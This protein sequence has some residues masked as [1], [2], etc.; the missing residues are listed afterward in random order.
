MP[1]SYV[2]EL[3]YD[4]RQMVHSTPRYRGSI[5]CFSSQDD[6]QT[7][8]S[9]IWGGSNKLKYHHTIGSSL[10]H[11]FYMDFNGVDDYN[12]TYVLTGILSWKD[13][14]FDEFHCCVV[15]KTTTYS[16]GSNTNYDLYG[17]YLIIPAA[18]TGSTVVNDADRVL[19]EVPVNEWGVRSGAGYWDADYNQSTK[20][21][22]NITANASGTGKYN[23][24]GTEV[25]FHK[26]VN[27]YIMLGNGQVKLT[28]FDADMLGHNVRLRFDFQT[29]G[30]DHEWKWAG[31]ITM[32]RKRTV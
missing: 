9:K 21:F 18:G 7:D 10:T 23:M 5:T 30:T 17:G 25:A 12:R 3:E 13:A 31:N 4:H 15:P 24:F 2:P 14:D 1:V 29:V 11:S 28:A 20:Q 6:D 32:F 22:E 26:Y 8:P 27:N 16:A 19:V